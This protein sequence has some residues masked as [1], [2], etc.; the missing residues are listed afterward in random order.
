MIFFVSICL[1]ATQ[2]AINIVNKE[3]KYMNELKK[4]LANGKIGSIN[5]KTP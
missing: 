4:L 5:L 3:I 2:E 1:K